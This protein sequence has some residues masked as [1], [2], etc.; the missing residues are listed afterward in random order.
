M[1]TAL[2][3]C[4]Q[5]KY[6]SEVRLELAPR[7]LLGTPLHTCRVGEGLRVRSGG[8]HTV[9]GQVQILPRLHLVSEPMSSEWVYIFNGM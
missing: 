9:R 1:N 2:A 6:F 7:I 5:R 3:G 4:C 8:L